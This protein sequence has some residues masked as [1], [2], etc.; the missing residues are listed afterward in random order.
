ME[1]TILKATLTRLGKMMLYKY[2]NALEAL[3]EN[4]AFEH[5]MLTSVLP[6]VKRFSW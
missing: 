6:L 3:E 4:S 2:K 1:V 5:Q